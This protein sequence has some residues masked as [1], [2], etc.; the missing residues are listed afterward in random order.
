M[1]YDWDNPQKVNHSDNWILNKI[2]NLCGIIGQFISRPYYKWGT[3]WTLD[4]LT[5]KEDIDREEWEK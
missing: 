3:F 1:N 4:E 5:F 2:G